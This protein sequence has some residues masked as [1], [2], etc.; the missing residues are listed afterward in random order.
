MSAASEKR[1]TGCGEL[2]PFSE[3]W[4]HKLGRHGLQPRCKTC[5]R[6]Q[7]REY[8]RNHLGDYREAQ[9][10]FYYS[11]IEKSRE[12]ARQRRRKN[13]TA[14]RARAAVR[15]AIDRGDLARPSTCP[16]CGAGDR[17][18]EAHH[19]DYTQPLEVE[20][21]CSKCHGEHRVVYA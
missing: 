8:R 6:A 15:R 4:K 13:L 20:W 19:S 11:N 7:V 18:I 12:E 9:K 17:R 16:K 5:I 14:A 21:L 3:Y 10:R 2:K 1:C